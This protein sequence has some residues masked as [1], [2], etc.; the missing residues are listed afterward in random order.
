ML[1]RNSAVP[2]FAMVPR[3]LITSSRDIPMPLS[4]IVTV[5]ASLSNSILIARS[6]SPSNSES[7]FNASKRSLSAASDALEINSLRKISLLE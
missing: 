7:S 1:L 5:L 4:E 3:L 2:D 6:L